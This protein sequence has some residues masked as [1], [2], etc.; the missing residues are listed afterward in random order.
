M[1]SKA[2]CTKFSLV[3]ICY[4]LFPD[5]AAAQIV[6]KTDL[7]PR[8]IAQL[9]NQRLGLEEFLDDLNDLSPTVLTALKYDPAKLEELVLVEILKRQIVSEVR[10]QDWLKHRDIA[11]KL[12]RAE[13]QELYLAWLKN[14]IGESAET[15]DENKVKKFFQQNQNVF[16]IPETVTYRKLVIQEKDFANPSLA[17]ASEEGTI[18]QLIELADS[19]KIEFQMSTIGP[20]ATAAMGETARNAL[21]GKKIGQLSKPVVGPQSISFFSIERFEKAL[22]R[23]YEQV[24]EQVIKLLLDN[25]LKNAETTLIEQI[26]KANPIKVSN[27][28]VLKAVLSGSS[29]KL[30]KDKTVG[31]IGGITISMTDMVSLLD[32]YSATEAD[33]ENSAWLKSS[34]ERELVRRY[35][36]EV[37]G[38]KLV[39]NQ[40]GMHRKRERARE[41][42]IFKEWMNKQLVLEPD[43][44]P[45][46]LVSAWYEE[47]KEKF[48]VPIS[49]NL[50]QIFI[51]SKTGREEV[52]R[53]YKLAKNTDL[54]GFAELAKKHSEHIA[55]A[56]GG[57]NLGWVGLNRLQPMVRKVVQDALEGDLLEPIETPEGWQII[58]VLGRKEGYAKKFAEVE[59]WIKKLLITGEKNR[60]KTNTIAEQKKLRN[61]E[62]NPNALRTLAERI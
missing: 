29:L 40:P 14:R 57:G 31:S 42:Q 37:G 47:N 33:F 3:L 41:N 61:I 21:N 22:V 25:E 20:V 9:Q 16:V 55:S 56:G 12:E 7:E 24:R 32:A 60:R 13:E 36:F 23:P 45:M 5:F 50:G 34:I 44:P 4:A 49:L 62:L 11:I 53:I 59:G 43:Y 1:S 28:F 2:F 52:D 51:R 35:I 27:L 46:K 58:R 17:K 30:N 6:Y 48:D 19:Q 26:K 10:G 39:S 18:D 15:I 38:A 8:V 54:I